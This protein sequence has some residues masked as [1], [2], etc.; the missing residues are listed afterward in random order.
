MSDDLQV[1]RRGA[2]LVVTIDRP[3]RMN[4]LS[5]EVHDGF[6][7]TW[8]ALKDDPLRPRDRHHRRR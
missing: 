2:V 8:T 3:E 7:A 4:T 1:E 5:Q 6:L